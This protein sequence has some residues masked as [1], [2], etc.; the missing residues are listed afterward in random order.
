[1]A[2]IATSTTF[3]SFAEYQDVL[4]RDSRLFEAN[5]GLTED[6]VNAMLKQSSQ[7]LLSMIKA[8]D[9]WKDY[10]FKR[11][12]SLNN[13][14]R[15]LPDV[16]P[17][18]IDARE[19]EFKDL[20]IYHSLSEYILP[21]VADF[22]NPD[23]AEMVKIKFYREQALDLFKIVL[24]TGDWYDYSNNGTIAYTEREPSRLNLVRVR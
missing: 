12:S 15:Q 20:N 14:V 21:S 24:E 13:D 17:F 7:R 16:N 2:F 8:T 19:Q 3:I 18:Q 10:N 1:M 11:N 9:W 6:S 5:E 22:G 4:D 23:S